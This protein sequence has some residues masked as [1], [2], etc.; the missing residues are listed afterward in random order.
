MVVVTL[1]HLHEA[2]A[3]YPDAKS[4]IAAWYAVARQ[5]R[6]KSFVDVAKAIPDADAVDGYTIFN[7]R[8]NRYRMVTVIHYAREIDGR[9]TM[10]HVYVR[11]FLTHKQYNDRSHWDK[12]YGR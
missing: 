12:E 9:A 8:R 1:K 10:G 4:E 5:A 6:W 7:V 11:S 3:K 2:A